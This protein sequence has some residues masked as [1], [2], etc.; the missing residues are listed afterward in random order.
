MFVSAN[1]ML[2]WHGFCRRALPKKWCKLTI[3]DYEGCAWNCDLQFVIASKKLFCKIGGDWAICC[4]ALRLVEGHAI[5]F[6]ARQ[7]ENN[8]FLHMRHFPLQCT[9][10][11]FVKPIEN[12]HGNHV[13][14]VN[15]Y[16]KS[17][18]AKSNLG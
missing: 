3:V 4:F 9:H 12:V 13:Y 15:Q 6:A 5:K 2:P 8:T 11:I 1:Q 18:P 14:Q 16:L 10:R 17:C 7:E